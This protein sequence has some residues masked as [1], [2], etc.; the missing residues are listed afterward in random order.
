MVVCRSCKA[1]IVWARH[2]FT[3]RAMP[4][5]AEPV[6]NGNVVLEGNVARVVGPNVPVSGPR[7]VS[8]FATCPNAGEHRRG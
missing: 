6:E 7:Y 8:H 1:P 2:E 3:R 5:D 4:L